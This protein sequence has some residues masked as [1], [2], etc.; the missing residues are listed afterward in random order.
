MIMSSKETDKIKSGAKIYSFEEYLE[1]KGYIVYT[2][3]GYSMT[4]FLRQRRDLVVIKKNIGRY[5]KYDVVLYKR[6]EKYILHRIL[7]VLPN[8]Y[9]IAG[10]HST[11]VENDVT[12]AMILGAMTRV[13]RD[14][15]SITPYN[16]LYKL[17]VHLWCDFFPIRMGI[18]KR[19]RKIWLKFGAV[20]RK[21]FRSTQN[22]ERIN[23]RE[24]SED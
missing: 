1:E 18:I 11:F 19:K 6:G 17:Y 24:S 14:G 12:D 10:D 5:K 21:A 20:K 2:I 13:I 16:I 9:L 3:S 23:G 22:D 8:G 7:K 4:P 15:K